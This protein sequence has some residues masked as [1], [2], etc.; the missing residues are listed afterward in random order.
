MPRKKIA[1]AMAG[2]GA[3]AVMYFGILDVFKE[4]GIKIDMLAACSSA[5]FVACAYSCGT[6]NEMKERAL[7]MER[8][9]LFNLFETSFKGGLFSL[10]K[11]EDELHK[12]VPY[13]NLEELPV[14]VAI[15]ASDIVHGDEVVFTMGNIAR[16]IK[17]SSSM[18]GLFEPVVWGERILLDGGLFNIIPVEAAKAWG[19]D[20]II[21]IDLATTRNLFTDRTLNFKRGI[22]FIKR[23]AD[24]MAGRII[25]AFNKI[26]PRN[27]KSVTI[28]NVK[29]PS[30]LKI[31][32]KAMDYAMTERRR[33][34][35][36]NCD[37]IIK[38]EVKGFGDVS[39]KK[40]DEM[41][42]EG[43]RAAQAALPEIKRL[44]L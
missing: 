11:I 36:F 4:N 30:M 35:Y 3:R 44:L 28:S 20:V 6:M 25:K 2:A 21:G 37:L 22:N 16:A 13:E 23:P 14:P 26:F 33:G 5:T 1:L 29:V 18:P 41:Y 7:S 17:A 27:A 40:G 39:V 8:K 15:V 9:D 19:A 12:F 32:D 34:E 31:M 43:R 10:D 24:Y 42:N 38:P